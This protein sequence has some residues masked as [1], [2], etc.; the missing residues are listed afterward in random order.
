MAQISVSDLTFAYEGSYDNIFE[1][2]SFTID[3]D[4]KIGLIGRNG[5][6][7]STF[8]KLLLGEYSYQG[9]IKSTDCFEY[10][11]FR[12]KK[13]NE[14][15]INVV[16]EISPDYELWKVIREL[17]QL[18]IEA[19]VL[20]RKFDSL[21][22]GERMKVMLAVLFAKENYFLLIDEPTNHLDI[23]TREVVKDY[24]R[25][26]KGFISGMNHLI[27]LM[28]FPECRLKNS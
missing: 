20:Y 10:F 17:E 2:V 8:L 25:S 6:G 11:P 15:T 3:S 7:K 1:N 24:L 21:S 27:I 4:W 19:D 16:E 22:Y 28:Y 9:S 5:T 14:D 18:K 26:K 13:K 12:I 23:E